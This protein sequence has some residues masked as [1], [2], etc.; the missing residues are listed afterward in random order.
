MTI[1][2][3]AKKLLTYFSPEERSI[4]DSV[5]YPG[6]NADVARAMNAALQ[7]LFGKG[8]PWVRKDARGARVYG[9]ANIPISVTEGSTSATIEAADWQAWMAGCTI[10]IVGADV[11]NEIRNDARNV[12][13]K[14]PYT[15]AT[16]TTTATVYCD[17]ITL[18]TDVME[19]YEPVRLDGRK[20]SP[21][22][23]EAAPTQTPIF[24]DY[25]HT[26]HDGLPY[27]APARTSELAGYAT[28]Y[29]VNTWT[30]SGTALPVVRMKL[31][32]APDTP[33]FLDYQALIAPPT[34]SDLTAT[35]V[36]PIAT[37]HV[38][39]IFLPIA[40]KHLA[41]SGF[42]R[43]MTSMESIGADYQAAL[44]LLSDGGPNRTSRPRFIAKG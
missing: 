37:H 40:I 41:N 7:E 38:E 20:L 32:P 16:G 42:F 28:G 30:A 2:D 43:G 18:A 11:D 39:S 23:S 13:L 27:Q 14:Y 8:R 34:V 19:I 31:H 24:P 1:N 15:G 36:L 33:G 5:T 21:L 12:V 35:A 6:R 9:P 17:S 29:F 10:V 22:M 44:A 3:L 26:D 25:G 4:P